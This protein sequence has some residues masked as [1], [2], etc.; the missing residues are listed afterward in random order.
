M[1]RKS[2]KHISLTIDSGLL[3]WIDKQIED[4]NFQSRSHCFEQAIN[5]LKKEMEKGKE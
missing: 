1:P 5:R 4:F 2:K 3:E